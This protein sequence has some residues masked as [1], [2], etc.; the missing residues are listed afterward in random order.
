MTE[1]APDFLKA[2]TLLTGMARHIVTVQPATGFEYRY[3]SSSGTARV[4]HLERG[5]LESQDGQPAEVLAFRAGVSPGDNPTRGGFFTSPDSVDLRAEAYIRIEGG[6]SGD[7]IICRSLGS[8]SGLTVTLAIY[9]ENQ[10]GS[11]ERILQ[12]DIEDANEHKFAIP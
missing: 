7:S 9:R 5:A 12:E 8:F 3:E 11:V 4:I 6:V 1:R 2:R 10:D